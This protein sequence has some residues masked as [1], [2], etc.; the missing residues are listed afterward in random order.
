MLQC[1]TESLGAKGLMSKASVV[2]I[3]TYFHFAPFG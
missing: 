1:T 2:N 3:L